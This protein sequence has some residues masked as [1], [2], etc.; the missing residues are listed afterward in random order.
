M[1]NTLTTKQQLFIDEYLKCFNATE[2]A[3]LAGYKG[4]GVTRGAVGYE[5]LKKPHIAEQI[6]MYL[7]AS[8]MSTEETL[9]RL[10]NF[11]RGQGDEVKPADSIRALQLIGKNS[12]LFGDN[13]TIKVEQELSRFLDHLQQRMR[14]ESYQEVIEALASE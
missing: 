4:N 9:M 2:A 6:K 8:A 12:G 13:L 3:K 1:S 11:A 14:P 5:N 10:G 7:E